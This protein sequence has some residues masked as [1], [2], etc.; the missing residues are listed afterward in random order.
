MVAR[1]KYRRRVDRGT[2]DWSKAC[3]EHL[4]ELDAGKLKLSTGS[5]Q[6]RLERVEDGEAASQRR[7][8]LSR[9]RP[10]VGGRGVAFR[11]RRFGGHR[12]LRPIS[13]FS[14]VGQGR[15]QSFAAS[16]IWK[17]AT[18]GAQHLFNTVGLT[19]LRNVPPVLTI[20]DEDDC[21]GLLPHADMPT[22]PYADTFC[23]SITP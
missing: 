7:A 5:T 12:R 20:D 6:A 2:G 16:G 22:R 14:Y 17:D 3:P 23:G 21:A 9:R 13:P 11:V 1:R 19:R 8:G 15:L 18:P 4:D 10:C